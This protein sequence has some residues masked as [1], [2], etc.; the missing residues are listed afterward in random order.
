MTSTPDD[1]E[2][3]DGFHLVVDALKLNGI[4]TIYTVPGIPITDLGRLAQ[5]SGIRVI[6][7]RHEQNA[8]NAAA[9]AGFLT[10]APGAQE[11]FDRRLER[12]VHARRE[13]SRDDFDDMLR[14][15]HADDI[16]EIGRS[17]RP[18]EAFHR[19]VDLDEIGAVVNEAQ[20]RNEIGREYA[21]DDKPR[22]VLDDNRRLAHRGRIAG[23]RGDSF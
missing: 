6:S 11:K 22:A 4:E 9:I 15:I 3:T 2:L 13:T 16:D 8:G 20:K 23:D 14:N 12:Y 5:G 19:L 21:I 7:F 17:H 1:V 10:K 18:A